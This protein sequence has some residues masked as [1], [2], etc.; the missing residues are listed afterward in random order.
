M[1]SVRIEIDAPLGYPDV[2]VT[3]PVYADY[4]AVDATVEAAVM[5]A[6]ARALAAFNA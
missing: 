5:L 4:G 1:A 2:T 3:A 6:A